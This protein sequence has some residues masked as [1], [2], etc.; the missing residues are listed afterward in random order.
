MIYI[1]INDSI[2]TYYVFILA[3][4]IFEFNYWCIHRK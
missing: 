4:Y 3:Y 1:L 2:N